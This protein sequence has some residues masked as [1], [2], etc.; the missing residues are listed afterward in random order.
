MAA[1]CSERFGANKLLT[2]VG[3]KPMYIRALGAIPDG[4]FFRVAVVTQYDEI[5]DEARRRGFTAIM[6]PR[7]KEDGQSGTVRLG[8]NALADAD[9]VM[10]MTADQPF[11]TSST[12]RALTRLYA[13]DPG[14]IAAPAANGERGNPCIFPSSLFGELMSITGDRGGSSVIRRHPGLL[15][16]LPVEPRELMD[17]DSAE[18]MDNAALCTAR[19]PNKCIAAIGAGGKTSLLTAL[20]LTSG[21][22]AC[23]TTTTHTSRPGGV[24]PL[25]LSPTR[26]ECMEAWRTSKAF[27]AGSDCTGRLGAPA[28]FE[29]LFDAELLLIEADGSKMLPLKLH[30]EHEPVIPEYADTVC[31]LSGMNALG[32]SIEETT[33]RSELSLAL[34][35]R[36][37][38]E[39]VD[40]NYI[41]LLTKLCRKYTP[42]NAE[43]IAVLNRAKDMAAAR[44]V[45][46]LLAKDGIRSII[47]REYDGKG[48]FYEHIAFD[49][50]K[51]S[52]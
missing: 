21:V 23:L 25:L 8:L 35:G 13:E 43:F 42:A 14:C 3:G 47:I 36:A 7:A 30:A 10:F 20:A 45:S 9:A 1:G 26:V 22:R 34:T 38:H 18:D 4:V 17:I 29:A 32:R 12:V 52:R 16:L 28:S 40:E 6:N 33:H 31:C 5:A 39:T 24:M 41:A 50:H 2:D 48:D 37:P 51:G 11:L 19:R 44:R 15:R 27:V 49:L 46:A